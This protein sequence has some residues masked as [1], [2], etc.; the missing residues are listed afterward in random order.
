MVRYLKA[1]VLYER[2][3]V[4]AELFAQCPACGVMHG[5]I[6]VDH[7][8]HDHWTWNGDWERPTFSPSMLANSKGTYPHL[9]RCHS[10]LRDGTWEFLADSTHHLAG[11]T[12]DDP[13]DRGYPAW[14]DLR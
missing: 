8:G 3:D 7:D 5:F 12:A 11:Q 4:I 1:A 14:Q 10:F 13:R 6:I 2:P 9:P